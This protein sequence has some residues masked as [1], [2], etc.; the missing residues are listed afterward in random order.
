MVEP[1]NEPFMTIAEVAARVGVSTKTVRREIKRGRLHAYRIGATW[2]V[3]LEQ[4]EG[5]LEAG[6][7]G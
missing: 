5:W 3:S 4:L 7:Q 1:T 6:G 2:R